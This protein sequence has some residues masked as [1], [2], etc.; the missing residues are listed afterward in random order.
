MSRGQLQCLG[1][2]FAVVLTRPGRA[3]SPSRVD[4]RDVDYP[5]A[6]GLHTPTTKDIGKS[7]VLGCAWGTCKLPFGCSLL[8][9]FLFNFLH[10]DCS[11]LWFY[12]CLMFK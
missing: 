2:V 3:P 9:K 4:L 7:M 8:H 1:R 6:T 10:G 12:A 5:H 11:G